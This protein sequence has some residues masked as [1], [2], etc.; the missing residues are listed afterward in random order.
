MSAVLC[1]VCGEKIR[2][3]DDYAADQINPLGVIH[4]ECGDDAWEPD[5]GDFAIDDRVDRRTRFE[6]EADRINS[7]AWGADRSWDV[8]A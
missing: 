5:Q 1:S 3:D 7:Q 4:I 2:P 8:I 6:I